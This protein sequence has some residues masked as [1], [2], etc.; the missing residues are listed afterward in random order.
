MNDELQLCVTDAASVTVARDEL[1]RCSR[2][3][4]SQA[5]AVVDCLT[6]EVAL[7]QG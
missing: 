7:I 1:K 6:R 3:D 2:L 4:A 5:D